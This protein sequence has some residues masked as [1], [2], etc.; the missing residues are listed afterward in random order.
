MKTFTITAGKL[1][2]RI[3]LFWSVLLV[4]AATSVS[5][6]QKTITGT[7]KSSEEG[8]PL[9]AVS[10]QVKGTSIGTTTDQNGNFSSNA[11]DNQ[12]LVASIVGFVTSES[13]VGSRTVVNFDLT[14]VTAEL[15]GV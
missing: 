14:S 8:M 10:I 6:Q 15:D 5:A 13:R 3:S 12:M 7:V 11:S 4:L 2:K 1:L 9:V